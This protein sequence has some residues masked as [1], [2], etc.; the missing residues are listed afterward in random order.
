MG[1]RIT[2][3]ALGVA[4]AI[5]G[6]SGDDPDASTVDGIEE[7]DAPTDGQASDEG[8]FDPDGRD[9]PDAPSSGTDQQDDDGADE[10]DADDGGGQPGSDIPIDEP[11]DDA[12]DLD[13][14]YA[15]RVLE[16][17]DD[18]YVAVVEVVREAGV[19]E[20]DATLYA[21]AVS[22][23]AAEVFSEDVEAD[24]VDRIVEFE[25]E[26]WFSS[27]LAPVT[28]D[29]LELRTATSE[30]I[31]LVVDRDAGSLYDVPLDG[32]WYITL[33]PRETGETDAGTIWRFAAES[34]DTGE[35]PADGCA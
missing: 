20:L 23:I 5:A 2:A 15:Q 28:S 26:G 30:C 14:D 10:D 16:V 17:L 13:A 6:C 11:V 24:A 32:R 4:M 31:S 21:A 27:E 29:V 3:L 19:D 9:E 1:R 18:R 25:S 12:S 22:P 33:R 34:P 7:L 8:A 35:E